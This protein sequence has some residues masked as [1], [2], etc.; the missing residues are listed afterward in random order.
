MHGPTN[1]ELY[2]R[3]FNGLVFRIVN[4]KWSGEMYKYSVYVNDWSGEGDSVV[5]DPQCGYL[6]GNALTTLCKLHR[7][8]V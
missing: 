1:N 4:L 2:H 7:T 6:A 5:S 3:H 8:A